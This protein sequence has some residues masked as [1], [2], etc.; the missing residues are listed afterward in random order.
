MSAWTITRVSGQILEVTRWVTDSFG[1]TFDFTL[2]FYVG[3]T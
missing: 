1:F 2:G 3:G